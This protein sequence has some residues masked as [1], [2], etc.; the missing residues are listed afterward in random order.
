MQKIRKVGIILAVT[1]QVVAL[2]MICVQR[3]AVLQTGGNVFL[4]TVPIDPRDLLRGDYMRLTYEVGTVPRSLVAEGEFEEMQKPARRVYLAYRADDRGVIIPIRLSLTRPENERYIR[5]RTIR[6]RQPNV[7][8]VHYGVEKFFV[9]Q[10]RGRS[11][12]RDWQLEGVRIPLEMKVAVGQDSGIAVLN[13]HRY[14]D[15]GLSVRFPRR[16]AQQERPP[17]RITVR[18]V[19]AS[20]QPMSIVDPQDHHTFRIELSESQRP[21]KK[22][23]LKFKQPPPAVDV[24]RQADIRMIMPQSV[25]EFE[26]DLTLPRYR[27]VRGEIDVAWNRMEYWETARVVY[28]VPESWKLEGLD[29]TDRLWKGDLQSPPFTGRN[30]WY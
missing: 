20:Q 25:Y 9:Q 23:A 6:N 24:Y 13:G 16:S 18:V 7:I 1:L 14:A 15:M 27:L 12:L 8:S 26:I 30:I 2:G 29:D 22:P 17:Y 19:N 11:L 4:R 3:E 5:G 10:D 28:R 21:V